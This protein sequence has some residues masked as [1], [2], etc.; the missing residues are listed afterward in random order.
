[1]APEMDLFER[2]GD[3]WSVTDQIVEVKGILN[4]GLE[5]QSPGLVR[6]ITRIVKPEVDEAVASQRALAEGSI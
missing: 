4:T 3:L 6:Y 1:M 2:Y 5:Q